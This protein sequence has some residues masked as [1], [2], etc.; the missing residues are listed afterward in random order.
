MVFVQF[1]DDCIRDATGVWLKAYVV[2]GIQYIL[3][4]AD[5]NMTKNVVI[6]L[7]YGPTTGPHDGTAEL[8][9]ALTALVAIFDG[10]MG[11]P[12]L[13]SFCAAGNSYL[14]EGH[15]AFTGTMNQPDHV[16][17]TWRLPPDNA[18]LC[19]CRSVDEDRPMPAAVTV[20]LTSPSGA[21][22]T[23]TT[24]YHLRPRHP[25]PPTPG[26]TH[27]SYGVDDMMWRLAVDP[28]IAAAGVRGR[29]RGLED[30]G[31]RYSPR[32]REVHAYVARSDPNMGVRTGAK[33]SYFVDPE[34]ERTRSAAASCNTPTGSSTRAG[35]LIHRHGTLNGIA[36][37]KDAERARRR[38][39]H[40]R[41]W[42]QVALFVGRPSAPRPP[43][44]SPRSRLRAALR[45]ILRSSG[46]TC[47]RQQERQRVPPDRHQCRG[48]ATGATRCGSPDPAS[49]RHPGGPQVEKYKR[50]DGNLDPP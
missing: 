13:R 47:R 34:W 20:T 19:F 10:C 43:P 16:E 29:A 26:C 18:V 45:R 1:A 49:A 44:T 11:S 5:P 3:S 24:A 4:F 25:L 27:R 32:T 42:T 8:E 21:H 48:T 12:S 37:A 7:S 40:S 28:T 33:L 35:S 15:V 46:H 38:W 39:L 2:D 23:S 36:T 30:Q 50:G 31:C 17:W 41:E 14:S 9:T 22:F 6:N